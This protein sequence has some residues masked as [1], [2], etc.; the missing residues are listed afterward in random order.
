LLHSRGRDRAMRT[1]QVEIAR[2]M[3][4]CSATTLRL[5]AAAIAILGLLAFP[6]S[7]ASGPAA[8]PTGG[9]RVL[10]LEQTRREPFR[11]R[12]V[13]FSSRGTRSIALEG[14][15]VA[16]ISFAPRGD[17]FVYSATTPQVED[18]VFLTRFGAKT[19]RGVALAR[20]R[21]RPTDACAGPTHGWSPGGKDIA[22]TT[23]EQLHPHFVVVRAATRARR[24]VTPRGSR[25]YDVYSNPSWSPNGRL[26]GFVRRY[27]WHNPNVCC[28]LEYHVMRPDGSG[29]RWIYVHRRGD[30][31]YD[32]LAF[33]WAPN[34]QRLAF[35]VEGRGGVSALGLVDL[36]TRRTRWLRVEGPHGRPAF[37]R[38]RPV[39][40]RDSRWIAVA[41][42]E[43]G[44]TLVDPTSRR[45]PRRLVPKL[46]VWSLALTADGRSLV[47]AVD[48]GQQGATNTVRIVPLDGRPSRLLY[49]TTHGWTIN[50][51]EAWQ[52]EE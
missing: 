39:W 14:R 30:S 21:C 27:G 52:A 40:S 44:I 19:S 33:A 45:Q 38:G 49:R 28:R 50:Q 1:R 36:H 51:L 43:P 24:E 15:F 5:A 17:R 41:T 31:A 7:S 23:F 4:S 34:S 9:S 46:P 47:A 8:A 22:V 11:Y 37:P 48:P 3:Q 29:R 10:F 35:T 42:A 16:H 26:I 25:R 2:E 12:A 18:S 32:S 13:E 6:A 20:A